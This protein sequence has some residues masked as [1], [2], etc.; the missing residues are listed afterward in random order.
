MITLINASA[1]RSDEGRSSEMT[2]EGCQRYLVQY[3][4]SKIRL[5]AYHCSL[6]RLVLRLDRPTNQSL[7][8]IDLVFVGVSDIRCPVLWLLGAIE[9][10][11]D[12]ELS[13]TVFR[14]PSADVAISASDLT[15]VVQD[16]Y[17]HKVWN[18]DSESIA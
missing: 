14:V 10:C 6:S 16:E 4:S 7:P 13:E 11:H 3:A 17:P 1:F 9:I 5:W 18:L 15:I 8:P 12:A 2:P